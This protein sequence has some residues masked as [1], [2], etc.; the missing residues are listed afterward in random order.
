MK[1]FDV[2]EFAKYLK[3]GKG[4]IESRKDAESYIKQGYLPDRLL[5]HFKMNDDT[6]Q[7][8]L[9][10]CAVSKIRLN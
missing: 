3:F 4:I 9:S 6:L 5:L 2:G 10:Q 8:V 1:P 7:Y